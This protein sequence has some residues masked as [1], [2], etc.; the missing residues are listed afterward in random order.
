MGSDNGIGLNNHGIFVSL[1]TRICG[2]GLLEINLLHNNKLAIYLSSKIEVE[3]NGKLLVSG[4]AYF[5][6]MTSDGKQLRLKTGKKLGLAFIDLK[7][8]YDSINR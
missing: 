8:A 7:R 6:N 5:I 1:N 3:S 4:G 2:K